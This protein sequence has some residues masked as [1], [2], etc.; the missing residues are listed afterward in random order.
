[1]DIRVI[2]NRFNVVF[3]AEYRSLLVIW[4]W[5]AARSRYRCGIITDLRVK[6]L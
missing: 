5:H 2:E 4:F 1:V 6:E 3:P